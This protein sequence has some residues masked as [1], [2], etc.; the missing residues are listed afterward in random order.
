MTERIV[1]YTFA[2]RVVHAAA[3][4]TYVY[5][6]LTGL[7][8]WTPALFWIAGVLGGGFLARAVH[9]WVGVIFAVAVL[10]MFQQWRRDMAA[11]PIDREWR[12]AIA[13]YI[14]N[15]DDRV[16]GAG[17]FN[18]GQKSL[19]WLMV[20]GTVVL[21]V[22]GVV[23]WFPAAVPPQARWLREL[24]ALAHAAA[25]LLT[26][27]G[28]IV[29]VYMGLLVVPGGWRAIV[30]GWVTSEWARRHHPRWNADVTRMNADPHG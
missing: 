3:A 11:T 14:R 23:L 28:F 30:H 10:R 29:H 6:L 27:G 18:Y 2:E 12:R 8:L 15:E 19:F 20:W 16:P 13:H 22:S 7:A 9:P 1:R 26:I 5:L 21:V 24:A 17:R 4:V 25:A